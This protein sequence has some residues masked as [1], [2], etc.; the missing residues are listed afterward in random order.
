MVRTFVALVIPQTWMDCLARVER[1]LSDRMSGLSW[2]KPENLHVTIRFLGD[3][4]DSGVRRAG[5]S[6]R[7][8]ADAHP[9]FSARLGGL[10]AFPSKDRPRVLWVGLAEGAEEAVAL[11]RSINQILQR[12]GFGPPDKPFRPHITLARV[13]ERAQSVEAFRDYAPP[14][15]PEAA[16]L[17][18]IV[19]MKSDLHPTGARYTAL[20]EIRLRKPGA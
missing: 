17:D 19:V 8:G 16:L 14:P 20:E 15:S 12:D 9:A 4:G 18:R 13:R 2:V 6:T 10:G 1:D 3:L 7:R 5:E 11:A